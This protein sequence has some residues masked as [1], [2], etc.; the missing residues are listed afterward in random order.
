[1]GV[2]FRDFG[3]FRLKSITT[4][5]MTLPITDER[6]QLLIAK[7]YA[8]ALYEHAIYGGSGEC[9]EATGTRLEIISNSQLVSIDRYVLEHADM[10]NAPI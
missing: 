6:E 2:D 10:N 7:G 8:L 5:F 1:M 4:D 3:A 9:T